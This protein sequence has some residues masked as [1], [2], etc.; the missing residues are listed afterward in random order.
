[1]LLNQFQ[2][3]PR[4]GGELLEAL[5]ELSEQQ[6]G[7]GLP[8]CAP[9]SRAVFLGNL[10]FLTLLGQAGTSAPGYG[11][12][13]RV[14]RGSYRVIRSPVEPPEGKGR[15]GLLMLPGS[16][17]TARRWAGRGSSAR[18]MDQTRWLDKRRGKERPAS[19]PLVQLSSSTGWILSQQRSPFPVAGAGACH[20]DLSS[21]GGIMGRTSVGSLL[22]FPGR[23]PS[24]PQIG[25]AALWSSLLS[26]TILKWRDRA[27][28]LLA[29]AVSV[30]VG[31]QLNR[32]SGEACPAG[33]P[34]SEHSD[35]RV[36]GPRRPKMKEGCL[37][38]IA[39]CA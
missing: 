39:L 11:S 12:V 24:G 29:G 21:A 30:Q 6:T 25:K 17:E 9:G 14:P 2:P 36:G 26:W 18:F 23:G 32:V 31:G 16:L 5:P 20:L 4:R 35:P 7:S 34:R 10:C 19:T 22:S 37:Y 1:M 3:E 38:N 28:V 15:R 8:V 27:G 13:M 33:M